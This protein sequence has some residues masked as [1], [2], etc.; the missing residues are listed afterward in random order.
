VIH[1]LKLKMNLVVFS[2]F[3]FASNVFG[4]DVTTVYFVP[5][6]IETY[7]PI[8]RATVISQAWEKWTISS[9]S[10]TSS[11]IALLNHGDEETFDENRVRV[12][13]LSGNQTFFIDANGVA[14][15]K[16]KLGIGIDKAMFIK[17]RDSLHTDQRKI[18]KRKEVE[19]VTR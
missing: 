6:E 11:L 18:L 17:F 5:L 3:I 8:T 19:E 13:I 2:L 9:K 1:L 7:V 12:L 10:Q 4:A 14:S 16:G 15:T